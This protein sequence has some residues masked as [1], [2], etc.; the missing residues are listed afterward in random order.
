MATTYS[1][2]FW[3]VPSALLGLTT[4]FGMGRGVPQRYSHL[5]YY[6]QQALTIKSYP[7]LKLKRPVYRATRSQLEKAWVKKICKS[8]ARL[9]GYK[10]SKLGNQ[11]C[12]ALPFLTLHLQ[13]IKVIVYDH[14]YRSLI[15]RRVSCLYAFSTYLLQTQLLSNATDVTTDTLAVCPTRSSR[16]RV[17]SSQASNAHNRQGPNCLTTF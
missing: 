3:A 4:L 9:R 11:Y 10:R 13:P 16:T 1:P 14:P 8:K 12:S 6:S 2:T 5:I 7:R 15:L 17:S